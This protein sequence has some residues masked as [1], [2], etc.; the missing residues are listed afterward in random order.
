MF[1]SKFSRLNTNQLLKSQI[2]L[3]L[4]IVFNELPNYYGSILGWCCKHI[5]AKGVLLY[6]CQRFMMY[7]L[8]CLA[9]SLISKIILHSFFWILHIEYFPIIICV[10]TRCIIVNLH[11]TIFLTKDYEFLV[12]VLL[13]FESEEFKAGCSPLSF[14][15]MLLLDRMVTL[16]AQLWVLKSHNFDFS[17]KNICSI[18]GVSTCYLDGC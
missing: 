2:W 11:S 9:I 4:P 13:T 12:L 18:H 5:L 10:F 16:N 15:K 17:I 14:Y 1:W 3:N 8:R 7:A 6:I